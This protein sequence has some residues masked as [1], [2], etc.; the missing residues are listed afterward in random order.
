MGIKNRKGKHG[1]YD[2]WRHV[3]GPRYSRRHSTR[4]LTKVD[5]MLSSL[6]IHTFSVLSLQMKNLR[7]HNKSA[8]DLSK[9]NSACG[10]KEVWRSTGHIMVATPYSDQQGYKSR[11][12][13]MRLYKEGH[14]P[15]SKRFIKP[16]CS[17]STAT[18]I[19]SESCRL[20][21]TQRSQQQSGQIT[22]QPVLIN[23]SKFL[24]IT[25]FSATLYCW[26]DV[27]CIGEPV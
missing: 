1:R 11:Q 9:A 4:S 3:I 13:V 10:H 18:P 25:G 23:K 12:K 2:R 8:I 17:I 16:P 19:D 22:L 6:L 21:T 15:M 24:N 26:P 14:R 7:W 5:M 20:P 27:I